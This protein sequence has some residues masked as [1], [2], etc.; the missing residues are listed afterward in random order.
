MAGIL[1]GIYRHASGFFWTLN[2]YS[3]R[4]PCS[5]LQGASKILGQAI[6]PATQEKL[7]AFE[8]RAVQ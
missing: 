1:K 4:I 2:C 3:E 6:W 5:L 7:P 8:K